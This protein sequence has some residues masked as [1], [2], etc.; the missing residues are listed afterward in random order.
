MKSNLWLLVVAFVCASSIMASA[1]ETI[2]GEKFQLFNASP[3]RYLEQPLAL[4]DTF[5]KVTS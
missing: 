4:E 3:E 5:G 2:T 1:D